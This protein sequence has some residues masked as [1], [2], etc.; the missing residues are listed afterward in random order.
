MDKG[1][2]EQTR[3]VNPARRQDPPRREPTEEEKKAEEERVK[4][5]QD[6]V[7]DPVDDGGIGG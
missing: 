5:T 3:A 2:L 7:L 4:G 6:A 1:E